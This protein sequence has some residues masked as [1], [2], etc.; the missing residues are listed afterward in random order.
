MFYSGYQFA[1]QT[2]RYSESG[3][4]KEGENEKDHSK[5]MKKRKKKED[6][7]KTK[8]GTCGAPSV[9]L[10]LVPWHP[11]LTQTVT[12]KVS[13]QIPLPLVSTGWKQQLSI[14]RYVSSFGSA[15]D[16]IWIESAV[17]PIEV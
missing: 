7:M 15:I 11:P 14:G 6:S 4:Q 2:R 9:P 13:K 12:E 1:V 8:S 10:D 5:N 17:I 16:G 3:Y